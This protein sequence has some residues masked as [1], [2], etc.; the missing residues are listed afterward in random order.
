MDENTILHYVELNN[1]DTDEEGN[2]TNRIFQ[3][4]F[5]FYGKHFDVYV[6]EKNFD[7]SWG[8]I[9]LDGDS[10]L[11]ESFEELMQEE[12]WELLVAICKAYIAYCDKLEEKE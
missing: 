9:E 10:S 1:Y 6:R 8:S 2:D 12:H 11:F 5:S 3:L 7:N 4:S